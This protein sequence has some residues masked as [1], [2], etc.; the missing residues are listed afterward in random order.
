MQ[1]Q[2]FLQNHPNLPLVLVQGLGFVGSVMSLVAANAINGDYVVIGIEQDTEN[3]RRIVESLN[4]GIFPVAADDPKIAAYFEAARRKGNF[5]ATT[6]TS[7][8]AR[9]DVIII[10]INLDVSKTSDEKD[11]LI[12]YDVNLADFTEAVKTIGK[13]CRK[14]A[15]VLVETTVPPGTCRNIVAPLLKAG[16]EERGLPSNK[17]R[18]GHSYERVMPGP[19]Y[20]DS[21]QNF[22]RVYS[23]IDEESADAVEAFLKTIIRTG[24]YPLTR[25]GNTNATEIAK[26]LENSYR[27]MNIAFMVEWSR[28]A[29]EAGVD[30]YE[31]VNAIR[32]RPTHSNLMFPGIGVGGYCLTKDPLLAS[33]ARTNLLGGREGLAQSEAAVSINDQMPRYAFEFLQKR[34]P[35]SLAGVK[36]LL[37]GVSYRGD[38]GDTRF[39][40][41]E[42]FYRRLVSAE[43]VVS[44]HDPYINHWP[45][46][47]LA[48]FAGLDEALNAD[49]DIVVIS[50]GHSLYRKQE[51]MEKLL[52]HKPVWIYDTIGL[53]SPEQVAGLRQKHR[54]IVLGRGDL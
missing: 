3:G 23:G 16:L 51:T 9:A 20:I 14:D 1:Y 45:E 13:Y 36:L 2:T 46:T 21:I 28:M 43:A 8:Y 41:A 52:A 12:D 31:I 38:V 37:L 44:V 19:D 26:V 17:I 22:Y 50:T 33:W 32:R 34:Y 29:E 35:G 27:A 10:D 40:P 18:V 25:L 30:L 48:P 49:P 15:L 4:A 11:G 54:V 42:P 6:D 7:V 53:F 24:E 39:S 5:Y 47:G